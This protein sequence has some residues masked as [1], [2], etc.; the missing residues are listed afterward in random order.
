LQPT[1]KP[2]GLMRYFIL[3]YTNPGDTVLDNCM[4]SGTT[5]VAAALTGRNFIGIEQDANYVK[6]AEK[7][8]SKAI[9][10]L[11]AFGP[12]HA[13]GD[14]LKVIDHGETRLKREG[15]V[16]GSKRVQRTIR[17]ANVRR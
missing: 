8:I 9:K 7:R 13:K 11:A 3:T 5:G 2:V 16:V 10:P 14:A 4:G 12:K 1:Q 15:K 17:Q 6:L